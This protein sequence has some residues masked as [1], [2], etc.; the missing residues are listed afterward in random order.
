MFAFVARQPILDR[1]QEVYAYELLFRDG[2][3]N[4][5]PDVER[6]EATRQLIMKNYLTL[7]LDDISCNKTSFINFQKDTLMHRFPESLNPE[8]VVVEVYDN[9]PTNNGFVEACKHIKNLGFKLALDNHK[10]DPLWNSLLP[11]IDIVKIDVNMENAA[12]IAKELPKYKDANVQLVANKLESPQLF[13]L[14]HDMGF[15][16]FQGYF[17]TRPVT[18]KPKIIPTSKL[19]LIDLMAESGKE[20]FNVDRVNQIIEHDVGLSYMLLRFINNPLV[21]KRL[22]ITSLRHALNYMGEVEV[23]KFIAL[24]ALANLSDDKPNELVHLSLVRARFCDLLANLRG[25]GRN[26]PTGFLVGLFSLL[27]TLLD[28]DMSILV[29]KLPIVE[30]VKEALCGR[31]NEIGRY[32]QL[33]KAY[34]SANWLKVKKIADSLSLDQ[35][36]LHSFYND[37]IVWGNNIRHSVSGHFPK[38]R[39]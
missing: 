19:T 27:D 30:D 36:Q 17:F 16:F 10:V 11:F 1:N 23:K 29:D 7:D 14:C 6:D 2:K 15:D 26:P 21:N 4:C 3:A 18:L 38:A 37:A 9:Q 5:Y 28:Q 22:K 32:L 34:E 39:P 31:D 8:T 20:T 13:N 35:K 24:L 33:A 25:I 12:A